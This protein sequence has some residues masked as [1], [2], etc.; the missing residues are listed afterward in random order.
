[1]VTTV[2]ARPGD[3]LHRPVD[4]SKVTGGSKIDGF[5]KVADIKGPSVRDGHEDEIEIHG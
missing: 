1:L 4:L 2:T 3:S 5:L